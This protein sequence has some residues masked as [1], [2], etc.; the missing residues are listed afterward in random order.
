M[1]LLN[2][3]YIFVLVFGILTACIPF[4]GYVLSLAKYL[5]MVVDWINLGVSYLPLSEI[6][7]YGSVGI[8]ALY[9]LYFIASK[10]VMLRKK[11]IAVACCI[12]LSVAIVVVDNVRFTGDTHLV[13]SHARYDVTSIVKTND[14]YAL[15][16]DLTK[17]C[18]IE[19]CIKDARIRSVDSI[20]VTHLKN[21]NLEFIINLVD[22]Y[23]VNIVYIREDTDPMLVYELVKNNVNVKQ[24]QEQNVMQ[25]ITVSGKFVGY[26]YKGILFTSYKTD[27]K[28]VSK[29]LLSSYKLVRAY[30]RKEMDGVN[31]ALNFEYREKENVVG[32]NEDTVLLDY[33]TMAKK[34]L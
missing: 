12:L 17:Y 29:E 7:V 1:P 5:F 2:L 21:N 20:Y 27:F 14:K 16:G 23:D 9:L 22:K 8:F 34:R 11:I 15:V 33:D 3:I 24:M 18:K 13:Y 6:V 25:E 32:A 26:K 4:F 31:F 19:K 30:S 10:Y 28:I